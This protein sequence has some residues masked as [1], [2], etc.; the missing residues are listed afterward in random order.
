MANEPIFFSHPSVRSESATVFFDRQELTL[1]LRLY[2]QM[3]ARAEWRD[4]GIEQTP[5][6]VSFLIF[7]RAFEQ[8]LYR[9]EKRPALARKQGAYC[10]FNQ[11]DVILNR[12]HELTQVLSLFDKKRFEA[13]D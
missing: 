6:S 4:Y 12:G 1:I 5:E 13:L 3:V 2:G 9:I 10:V 8:P 7:R 11:Q